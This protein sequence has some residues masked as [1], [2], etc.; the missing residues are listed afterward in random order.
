[1]GTSSV[2]EIP[3]KM[4]RQS[5]LELCRIV[6]MLLL[7]AHHCVVHG[8]AVGMDF[9]FNKYFSM[10]WMPVGKI[11][12]DCF[13]AISMWF[14]VD[15][16]FKTER[17]LR[18][19]LEVLFYSVVFFAVTM[20]FDGYLGLRNSVAVFF[21]IAGNSHG[22]AAAYLGFY[23]LVPFLVKITKGITKKQCGFL[24]LVLFY[25]QCF[26]QLFGHVT[27]YYQSL[28]SELLLFLL[29][30]YILYYLK[31]WPFS[32]QY[33][34]GI[35]FLILIAIYLF[36]FIYTDLIYAG[37]ESSV[38]NF[39]LSL[40]IG[41]T[42]SSILNIIGGICLFFVFNNIKMPV[43]PGINKIAKATFGILLIHDHNFFRS[44]LWQEIFH[45]QNWYY[46]HFFVIY[47]ILTVLTVFVCCTM[48][49]LLR[50]HYLENPV[51]RIEKLKAF[52]VKFD[53][54]INV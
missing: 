34:N 7:I 23:L 6:C 52:C 33:R 20:V 18:I 30:Y 32:F 39:L 41:G 31:H 15:R 40:E 9:C 13:L 42:E 29:M 10:L 47:F 43:T 50:M 25:L 1:M 36:R 22:F 4:P 2:S 14:L 17:F 11:A 21:P 26:S 5:N 48:I 51:F 54:M 49:D 37:T 19:W 16:N 45:A 24:L 28:F 27:L 3:T 12:F 44:V 38:V 46:S 35:L 53:R 8:G